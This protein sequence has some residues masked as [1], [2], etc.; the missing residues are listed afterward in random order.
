MQAAEPAI[1]L[2]CALGS[3]RHAFRSA[4][5]APQLRQPLR[6][7]RPYTQ[8]SP[9]RPEALA[10]VLTEPL[11]GA[12]DGTRTHSFRHAP[13]LS[14]KSRCS[15]PTSIRLRVITAALRSALSG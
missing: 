10:R 7:R 3:L 11:I 12:R 6:E 15:A 14:R 9:C 4:F 1:A 8:P 13:A 5:Q 2:G